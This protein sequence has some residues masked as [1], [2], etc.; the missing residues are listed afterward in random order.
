MKH[1]RRRH[2]VDHKTG[3]ELE[4]KVPKEEMPVPSVS[5]SEQ[6]NSVETADP[7]LTD[8][9]LN[10]NDELLLQQSLLNLPISCDDKFI[11]PQQIDIFNGEL[12][13]NNVLFP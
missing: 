4:P 3:E 12:F 1:T 8:F 10:K 2:K 6:S 11:F 13:L 5:V 7:L 9:S